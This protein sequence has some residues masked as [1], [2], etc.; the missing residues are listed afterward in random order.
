MLPS[1]KLNLQLKQII[2][3]SWDSITK[4]VFLTRLKH[5]WEFSFSKKYQGELNVFK[6]STWKQC[7]KT[8]HSRSKKC[9]NTRRIHACFAIFLSFSL[10]FFSLSLC[11][12]LRSISKAPELHAPRRDFLTLARGRERL[13]C[14]YYKLLLS[15]ARS[16]CNVKMLS[17]R[18]VRHRSV[19][20][21]DAS[22]VW[23][24]AMLASCF[25]TRNKILVR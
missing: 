10:I 12:N 11:Q 19:M 24:S 22:D 14:D 5:S 16:K 1:L 25:C 3:N 2:V 9:K 15:S 13:W 7:L 6:S 17:S 4:N 18:T 21:D 8:Q 20:K 23:Q